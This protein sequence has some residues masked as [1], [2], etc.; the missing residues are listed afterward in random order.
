M[1]R[2]QASRL[3]ELVYMAVRLRRYAT[4]IERDA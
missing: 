4:T 3:A 1:E 2:M